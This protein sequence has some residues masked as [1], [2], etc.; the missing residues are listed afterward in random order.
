[1][2]NPRTEPSGETIIFQNGK[3]DVPENPTIPFI[4][5]DGIGPEIWQATK[6][7]M[8]AAVHLAYAQK[9]SLCW[10]EV[11]AGEKAIELTGSLLPI[12]TIDA[13]ARYRVG[14]KGP[15]ATPVGGG[16]RSLNVK[17]R[18]ALDL[19]ICL[20][21]VSWIKGVP[22][23]VRHPEK[24]DMVIFRENT[25]D[26]Y[27]GMEFEYNSNQAQLFKQLMKDNF[28]SEFEKLRFPDSSAFSI[29]PISRE[30]SERLIR[31][32]IQYA[33]KHRRP[34]VTL[35]HKGNIMKFTEGAFRQW[36]YDLAK[37]EFADQFSHIPDTSDL[38]KTTFVHKHNNQTNRQTSDMRKIILNDVIADAAFEQTLTRPEEFDVIATMNLNGDY[39]SDALTA[40]VGGLG[41]APGANLNNETC[42]AIFEATHGTAP[43]LAGKNCA[44]PCSLILSG[45]MLLD[46]LGWS[47]AA[48]LVRD[49][50]QRTIL[51]KTV[52]FDFQRSIHGST[53]LSTSEFGQAIIQQMHRMTSETGLFNE[54]Y[55]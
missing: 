23:P 42:T 36:G 22:T 40:Q 20:R 52:T 29:K 47:E 6:T 26:I 31:A 41:I 54:D 5:G 12:E 24:I 34:K 53:C 46:H 51:E 33:I 21:P 2:T 1:M 27:T 9:R 18:Q 38:E 13:F 32:A 8:D 16:F 50:V 43:G 11:Y 15:L 14:L 25:E 4:E 39:L 48:R 3:L 30:G 19:Y 55:S 35:I 17:I 45:A 28:P 37:S 7:V 44:N 10:A 49:S